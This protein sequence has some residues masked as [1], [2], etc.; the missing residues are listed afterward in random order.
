MEGIRKNGRVA[1]KSAFYPTTLNINFFSGRSK[2]FLTISELFTGQQNACVTENHLRWISLV[3]WND[4]IKMDYLKRK[5][6][7]IFKQVCVMF[8]VK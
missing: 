8:I 2:I 7:N 4:M 1:G 3:K 5:I 6:L